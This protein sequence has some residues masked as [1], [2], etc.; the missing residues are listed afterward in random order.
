MKLIGT[1]YRNFNVTKHSTQR[2]NA[3]QINIIIFTLWSY[4]IHKIIIIQLLLGGALLDSWLLGIV[5][6]GG[7]RAS[8]GLASAQTDA[9]RASLVPAVLVS[10]SVCGASVVMV[11]DHEEEDISCRLVSVR[12]LETSSPPPDS[13]HAH[14]ATGTSPR[15][16]RERQKASRRRG[17]MWR[18]TSV[19][20]D[21]KVRPHSF[22]LIF[23][24]L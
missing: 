13:R 4:W 17:A 3:L 20:R 14:Q 6:G 8:A 16:E 1:I 9:G 22:S 15:R 23:W 24:N 7:G 2:N 19:P 12:L 10:L 11:Y 21:S 18:A 5:S